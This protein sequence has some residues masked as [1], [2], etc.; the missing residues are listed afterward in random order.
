[1]IYLTFFPSKNGDFYN[2][3]QSVSHC[4]VYG[5]AVVIELADTMIMHVSRRV[6]TGN[7]GAP[8]GAAFGKY[9]R[10]VETYCGKKNPNHSTEL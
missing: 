7:K 8:P 1:M 3:F 6:G 10:R 9:R 4:D 5:D 2:E